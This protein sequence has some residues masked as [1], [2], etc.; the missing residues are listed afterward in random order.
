[1]LS[2]CG[3]Q[4][5]AERGW[6]IS[7]GPEKQIIS[8]ER[9]KHNSEEWPS[10]DI[11][12]FFLSTP[13][14]SPLASLSLFLSLPLTRSLSFWYVHALFAS[15]PRLNTK[16]TAKLVCTWSNYEEWQRITGKQTALASLSS[17]LSLSTSQTRPLIMLIQ[18]WVC[19]FCKGVGAIEIDIWSVPRGLSYCFMALP[20]Y[21]PSFGVNDNKRKN[22]WSN[23]SIKITQYQNTIQFCH[24]T[25]LIVHTT[26]AHFRASMMFFFSQNSIWHRCMFWACLC[27]N[28]SLDFWHLGNSLKTKKGLGHKW[29]KSVLMS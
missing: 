19:F 6:I 28:K 15:A 7:A 24:T 10:Q 13:L 3:V 20:R 27:G 8:G 22:L 25:C 12:L 11:P 17:S 26:E 14:L 21:R 4:A 9:E 16:H 5:A 29:A 23:I 1:M 18:K 2:V